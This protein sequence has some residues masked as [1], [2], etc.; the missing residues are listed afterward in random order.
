MPGMQGT[1]Q[2]VSTARLTESAEFLSHLLRQIT[3]P[4]AVVNRLGR[5]L[6]W[7]RAFEEL[8]GYSP[9]EMPRL[10]PSKLAISEPGFE[11]EGPQN[12]W[13][14]AV[15]QGGNPRVFTTQ[16]RTRSQQPFPV[17]LRCACLDSHEGE[18][19][20]LIVAT[21][22]SERQRL[23]AEL[24]QSQK[25]EAIGRLAGGIAHDFNNVL[26]TILGLSEAMMSGHA[27]P[28]SESLREIHHAASHAADLTNGL[29]AFSRRQ[30]LQM[31]NI[32]LEAV[33]ENMAK[34]VTR[35]IGEDIRLEI[36][37]E[38][39]LPS[40]RADQSQIEQVVLNLCLNARDA[41]PGGGQLRIDV[42]YEV[43][44]EQRGQKA[45]AM[46]TGPHVVLA[47]RDSGVGMD[48]ET[49]QHVFEPFFT[50]KRVGQGTGLGLSMVYGIVQQHEGFIHVSS[51]PNKG[52][53]FTIYFPTSAGEP[54][55]IQQRESSTMATGSGTVMVVE[56]EKSVRRLI[57]E[58]LPRLGYKVF[59]AADGEEALR[60][61]DRWKDRID[62]VVL[63]A[64]LPKKS[65]REVYEHITRQKPSVRFLFTSGYNEVFI[66][67]KFELDPNFIF[68][69]KPFSTL[70]LATMIRRALE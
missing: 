12:E 13:I 56:D 19:L 3:Q 54:E 33:V 51:Q 34:M 31:R 41:M 39:S 66:N 45:A 18:E 4:Y 58:V 14:E 27:P 63:D 44:A 25:M 23:E 64:I 16:W 38:Q 40:I 11:Q 55:P 42:R 62:L 5:F 15:L 70:E 59:A 29:L 22:L 37:Y 32:R 30:I 68:L 43:L 9:S 17:E 35:L 36:F 47:V 67:R 26:T 24:R 60:V 57:V 48:E 65:S 52:T 53:E 69:R 50:R 7:N 21:N 46:R 2:A 1:Q 20:L 10:H 28:T 8:T 49:L 61:F 6:L